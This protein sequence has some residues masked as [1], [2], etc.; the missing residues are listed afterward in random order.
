VTVNTLTL[1][2]V[3]ESVPQA[4][5]FV[6]QSVLALG[7]DQACDDAESL[8]SE[9]AT[10]AVLHA[11]T[12]YTITVSRTN[13]TIKVWV[14]DLS[15]MLPRARHYGTDSTTGRGMRLVASL[16]LDW[17]VEADG[18]GKA[19]WFELDAD[20]AH[21]V[22]D[23]WDIVDVDPDQLLAAFDDDQPGSGDGAQT[24]MMAA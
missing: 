11:R 6:R 9:L 8:V 13:G 24:L 10:N 19:I 15:S 12:D 14:R 1:M 23:E 4:R 3:A 16:A 22:G 21:S 17:G 7:A 2:A 20:G 18:A 5:R